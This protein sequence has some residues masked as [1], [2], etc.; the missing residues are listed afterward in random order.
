MVGDGLGLDQARS[1]AFRDR[2]YIPETRVLQFAFDGCSD[3]TSAA[4]TGTPNSAVYAGLP[5]GVRVRDWFNGLPDDR[6]SGLWTYLKRP[7]GESAE[8]A[9]ELIRLAWSSKATLAMVSF[10]DLLNLERDPAGEVDGN[11]GHR[12]WRCSEGMMSASAFYW[13]RKLTM[14][15]NRSTKRQEKPRPAS[16]R[17]SR[18]QTKR[19]VAL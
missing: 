15:S 16:F 4:E 1:F 3:N 18:M 10:P 11:G 5:D 7:A 17:N 2:S 9:W 14:E 6:R 12:R 19:G 13:L 8:I